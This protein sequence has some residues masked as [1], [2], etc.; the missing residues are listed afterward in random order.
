[1]RN[2]RNKIIITLLIVI[3]NLS[4][5]YYLDKNYMRKDSC[6]GFAHENK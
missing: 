6:A 4:G 1:M 3:L 2:K 5:L